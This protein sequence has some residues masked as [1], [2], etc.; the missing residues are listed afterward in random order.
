MRTWRGQY[1]GTVNDHRWLSRRFC[2]SPCV[3]SDMRFASLT[4]SRPTFFPDCLTQWWKNKSG[5]G[6]ISP[7]K[8]A[9]I[10]KWFGTVFP[11]CQL[12][13]LLFWGIEKSVSDF[14]SL[15]VYFNQGKNVGKQI[16]R[17][18]TSSVFARRGR[19]SSFVVS[20][21]VFSF[22]ND[23][24]VIVSMWPTLS[25]EQNLTVFPEGSFNNC[26]VENLVRTS[27]RARAK[28]FITPNSWI[29]KTREA[30]PRSSQ[31]GRWCQNII[32]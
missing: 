29:K 12:F 3:A 22:S 28:S 27:Q 7:H 13:L 16:P 2:V 5:R 26:V 23:R 20:A 6:C 10:T 24:D 15:T 14:V 1:L 30:F 32:R 19:Y 25:E 18:T 8:C 9:F 17:P 21:C 11:N 4:F 31:D